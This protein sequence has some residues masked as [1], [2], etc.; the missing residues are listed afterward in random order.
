[1]ACR[2]ARVNRAHRIRELVEG[3]LALAHRAVLDRLGQDLAVHGL[4]SGRVGGEALLAL[5]HAGVDA[6]GAQELPVHATLDELTRALREVDGR[7]ADEDGRGKPR[8]E[9]HQRCG[10]SGKR[11]LEQ[12]REHPHDGD[13]GQ[14]R[15]PLAG[16]ACH[17]VGRRLWDEGEQALLEH[18]TSRGGPCRPFS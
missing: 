6:A 12:R 2:E 5:P 8:R 4:G 13:V 7:G 14:E 9:R 10:D 16:H 1:M 18:G 11:T 17:D 15:K 3:T